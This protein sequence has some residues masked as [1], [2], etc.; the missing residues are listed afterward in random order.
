MGGVVE[1]G[2][3]GKGDLRRFFGGGCR[4]FGDKRNSG[5]GGGRRSFGYL[6][7]GHLI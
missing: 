7:L 2:G 5:G 6:L 4:E 1:W 3:K